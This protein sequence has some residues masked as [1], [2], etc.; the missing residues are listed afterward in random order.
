VSR[1][2]TRLE[3]M[4]WLLALA[5]GA[6]G[7][8]R[9]APPP[10]ATAPAQAPNDAAHQALKGP[11]GDHTPRHNGVVLM[12]GDV[13]YE[14]VLAR[15]GRHQV[16]FSDAVRNELPASVAS[17]VTMTVAR[18]GADVES[19][20]LAIDD[21]GESWQASGK[22]LEGDGASVTVRYLLQ[23]EAHETEIPVVAAILK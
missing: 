3:S 16:W 11:H 13:H 22:P 21:N 12:F 7:G 17:S 23:G 20:T 14:V 19:L 18:A 10:A 6:C 9:P 15:N 5:V 2:L 1:A 4:A 8:E